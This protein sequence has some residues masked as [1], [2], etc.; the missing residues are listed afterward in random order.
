LYKGKVHGEEESSVA[1]SHCGNEV[2]GFFKT[3]GHVFMTAPT[4]EDNDEHFVDD[5][6][7]ATFHERFRGE[8]AN[9]VVNLLEVPGHHLNYGSKYEAE[10]ELENASG[11]LRRTLSDLN[12]PEEAIV[13]LHVYYTD[14]FVSGVGG[15]DAVNRI[16]S[17]LTQTEIFYQ[18]SW[19]G[20]GTNFL[21]HVLEITHVTGIHIFA[22][23]PSLKH[24]SVTSLVEA[25]DP[26]ARWRLPGSNWGSPSIPCHL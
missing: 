26:H 13:N 19:S 20:L 3:D 17:I 1:I 22:D 11:R 21:F 12:P 14:S 23:E 8:D 24:T 2:E 6:F 25:S 7:H 15:T 4:E 5:D 9:S 16:L 18:N 10:A